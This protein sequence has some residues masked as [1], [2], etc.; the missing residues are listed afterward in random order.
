VGSI[1]NKATK[2]ASSAV[3]RRLYPE[4]YSTLEV[5]KYAKA[6]IHPR[7]SEIRDYYTPS[8][9]LGHDGIDLQVSK[10]LGRLD[11][12]RSE[13]YQALFRELRQDPLINDPPTWLSEGVGPAELHNGF[14]PTPDAEIY[15]AMILDIEPR[16]IVEVGSGYSSLIARRAIQYATLPTKLT[17]ID[18]SP[19]TEVRFAADEIANDPVEDSDLHHRSWGANDILFIDSSHIC[20]SR[21][22]VAYLFCKVIPTLPAGVFVHVHDIFIPYDYPTN[23]DSRCYNEQYLLYCT[24]SGS[25]RYLTILSTHYLA[26]SR[27]RPMQEVFSPKVGASQLYNGASYWFHV[28]K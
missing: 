18:P 22:D 9:L 8:I 20:R 16:N 14:Y 15:G 4:T 27:A 12:W 17:V 24:L 13:R 2:A 19:R 11:A 5:G 1:F 26:R 10:Q 28:V 21:G 3:L 25:S 23:Y 7:I 6:W